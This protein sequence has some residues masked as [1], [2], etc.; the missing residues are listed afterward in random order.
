MDNQ[1]ETKILTINLMGS[2]ET[3]RKTLVYKYEKIY[4]NLKI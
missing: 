1:Q 2:S 3:I 4:I